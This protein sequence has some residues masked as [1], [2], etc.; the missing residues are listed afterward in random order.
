MIQI[1]RGARLHWLKSDKYMLTFG[2]YE[3]HLEPILR[4]P[5]A[6]RRFAVVA[7]A[8]LRLWNTMSKPLS[9]IRRR[10]RK[11]SRQLRQTTLLEY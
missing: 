9:Q 6:E 3:T 10:G 4:W 8:S 2:P 7:Q 11:T 5:K 1:E